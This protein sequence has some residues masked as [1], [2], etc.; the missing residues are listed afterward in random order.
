M[1][2]IFFFCLFLGVICLFGTPKD[3][4]KEYPK[5]M[6]LLKEL[7]KIGMPNRN[8][9]TFN[10]EK[11]DPYIFRE[12]VYRYE[13]LGGYSREVALR[14]AFEKYKEDYL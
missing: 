13:V 2:Q 12:Y 10:M 6:E 5:G 11:I 3:K 14:F 1:E 4:E 7:R 9:C 8:L